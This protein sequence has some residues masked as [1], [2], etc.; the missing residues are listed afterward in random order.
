METNKNTTD[1]VQIQPAQKRNAELEAAKTKL[2]SAQGPEFWRSLDEL[3][4][5]DG[6]QDLLHREFP[7]QAGEW[8]DEVSRRGF[9]KLMSASLALAGLTGCVKMPIESIVPYVRQPEEMIPGRPLFFASAFTLGGYGYPILVRSNEGR[10]TKVE[11]NPEHPESRGGTDLYTQASVLGL[12]E[13]DRSQTTS[14]QG[15]IRSWP[16]FMGAVRAPL[17]SQKALKGAGLRLLTGPISS[18][19]AGSQ[20]ATLLQNF[21][22]AKWHQWTPLN[23][24]NALNGAIMAFGQPVETIYQLENA[25]VIVSLDADFLYAGFPGF[26][27]HAHAWGQR[28]MPDHPSG[29]TRLYVIE[30]T[31][32]STG[33]KADHRLPVRPSEI[34]QFARALATAL[35]VNAGGNTRPE[36]QAWVAAMVKDLKSHRGAAVIIAGESQPP[37]VHAIAHAINDALGAPGKTVVFSDPVLQKP[38]DNAASLKELIADINA[39]KVDMLVMSG[40]NPIFDAPGDADFA[41]VLPKVPLKI[42]HGLYADETALYCDWHVNATHYLEEWSDARASNG[43][44]SIAQPLIEPL[45]GGRS[46]HEVLSVLNGQP[47]ASG[48]EILRAYWRTQYKGGD[49]E[50]FWRRA[51]HDGVIDGTALPLRTVILKARDFPAPA[52]PKIEGIEITFRQDPSIYDGRFANNPWLQECPKPMTKVTWENPV[53]VS[54]STAAR[55]GLHGTQDADLIQIELGGKKIEIPI[56]IQPGQP[57]EVLTLFV[58][59]GRTHSGRTGTA[60]GVNTYVLRRFEGMHSAGGV[61]VKVTGNR[62]Q[63]ASTQGYQNIE[64]RNMVRMA[65]LATYKQTP[66]FAHE[67]NF[68]PA[69]GKS[70][71]PNYEYPSKGENGAEAYAWGMSIDLNSCVGCNACIIACQSENNIA[72]VGKEQVLMGRHMHWIRVDVY[73]NGEPQN[74]RAYFEPLPCMQCERAPC[75]L[76]CPV[77]ATVHSSEGLNDMVYNRCVGTRYCSNNC[78]W[79]VRR[80]NFLLFQDWNTPQLKMG[81]NP[82]VTV[83]SRGVMEKCTYCV[84]RITKARI[85]AEEQDRR[86]RDGEIQTACQQVCPANAIVFGDIATGDTAVAKRKQNPRNYAV[87]EDLNTRPRTTHLA[88]VINPNPEMPVSAR[89]DQPEQHF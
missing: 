80:F 11:G 45:Y 2:A 70:M 41:S 62:Y 18:P 28:R 54:P 52:S 27:R 9:L 84:Q 72:V 83:R 12:Y 57:D 13:P 86:V 16:S 67:N 61:K 48:Y 8:H 37:V 68:A 79:K 65:T 29:M 17:E 22:Q 40:V 77:N 50:S 81:R 1:L 21:P 35:G 14:Y 42:H 78:P 43:V 38:V 60:K 36:H 6:F 55:L 56:W 75:E 58:G 71:Y 88:A 74:P 19:T 53:L 32:T 15:E 76:V 63:L 33:A 73:Y 59:G 20:I 25:D 69:E 46:L 85:A 89:Q 66:G 51:V 7:R 34:E 23:R 4:D 26:L 31:A 30:G 24:D 3:A 82:E 47:D 10:P 87:L 44:A 49:F 64:G 39:G 5:T